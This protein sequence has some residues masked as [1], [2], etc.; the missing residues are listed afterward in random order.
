MLGLNGET[1]IIP[2]IPVNPV[3]TTGAGDAFVG[4]LLYQLEEKT[5]EEIHDNNKCNGRT[6]SQ[7][8][9]KPVQ[10]HVNTWAQWKLQT[11]KQRYF[12]LRD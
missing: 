6:L 2:S 8:R 12:L 5:L 9:I 1:S 7:M 3:D 11:F 10:E 4:A